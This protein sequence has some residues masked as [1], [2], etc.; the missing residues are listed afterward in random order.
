MINRTEQDVMKNWTQKERPVVSVCCT[1]FN[2]ENFITDAIDS[3]LMQE[4]DF[5]FEIIVRDDYSTD[6]TASIL[7]SYEDK[8]PNILKTIYETENQYSKGIRPMPVVYKRAQGKYFAL[9]E[10]DDYWTDKL[11]LQK[12][13]NFLEENSD[14]SLC[15][16]AATVIDNKG[17]II[18]LDRN[19]GDSTKDELISGLGHSITCSTMFRRFNLDILVESDFLNGDDLLWHSLGFYGSCKYLDNINSSVYRVHDKGIWSGRSER[20]RLTESLKTYSFIRNNIISNFGD[21]SYLLKMNEESFE[22]LFVRYFTNCLISLDIKDYIFGLSILKELEHIKIYRV[23]LYYLTHGPS[24]AFTKFK[25]R[26]QKKTRQFSAVQDDAPTLCKSEQKCYILLLNYNGWKDTIECLESVLRSNY[27]NYQ[28]IVVDND[29]Q[30]DSIQHIIDWANRKQEVIYP[31]D[32]QLKGLSQPL[33]TTPIDY[34]LYDR[35]SALIGGDPVIEAQK[36][37]P[38]ILIQSGENNGFAAGNNIGIEYVLAK[39]DAGYI[40]ILN[41]DTV[42]ETNALCE[43][44]KRAVQYKNQQQNIGIIG[45]KLM[46]YHQPTKLESVGGRYGKWLASS[47]QVGMLEK[48]SGQYDNELLAGKI[49]YHLGASMFVNVDFIKDVGLMCEDYFIYFEEFD[50]SLRGKDKGWGLGFCWTT[51][52]YHKSGATIGSHISKTK[53]SMLSDYYGLRNR[54]LITRKFFPK[55]IHTVRLAIFYA[56]LRRLLHLQFDRAKVALNL[57]INSF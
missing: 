13:V 37:S 4:T 31:E 19:A 28:I 6:N 48:D 34:I 32:T 20:S 43:L 8:Y 35:D 38:V 26:I 27:K 40:W 25:K 29:S 42:V 9:C 56:F 39:N 21:K 23:Y 7:R 15:Y 3:F 55:Y 47:K 17:V 49:D 33:I 10:G 1:T 45:T 54:F 2:H 22:K 41:N 11:K 50:W 5:P 52:I 46:L 16:T 51:K 12:Q 57:L 30:N 14:F 36:V 18:E 24:K 44:E 53:R